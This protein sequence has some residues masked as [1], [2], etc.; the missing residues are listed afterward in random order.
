[1]HMQ[2]GFAGGVQVIPGQVIDRSVGLR[3]I[4]RANRLLYVLHCYDIIKTMHIAR[5]VSM[6]LREAVLSWVLE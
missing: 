5:L 3:F 6:K 1:M 2:F 4:D